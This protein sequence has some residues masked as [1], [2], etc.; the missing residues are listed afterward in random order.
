[1]KIIKKHLIKHHHKED[2]VDRELS[3]LKKI[4][5]PHIVEFIDCFETKSKYYIVFELATG[6]ELFDR[7]CQKGKFTEKDAAIVITT[8]LGAVSFLHS[9]GIVHRDIKPENLLYRDK[10]PNSDL[11]L[12]DFGISKMVESPEELLTTVCGSPGYTAPEILKHEPYSKP[13]DMWSIGVITYTLLC[14]H[15]PF[16]YAEDFNQMYNAICHGRYTFDNIYWAY[17]SRYA[18]DF[19][20]SLLQV[21]P[22]KRLT[23][24]EA[25][26]HTWLVKLCPYQIERI[27]NINGLPVTS[28]SKLKRPI[29]SYSTSA[30]QSE[31]SNGSTK[32]KYVKSKYLITDDGHIPY[33]IL[34]QNS[35]VSYQSSN[36]TTDSDIERDALPTLV[37]YNPVIL[38]M[39]LL[40]ELVIIQ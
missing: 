36:L 26:Q 40:M 8:I 17:I 9:R 10:S 19:I 29:K 27:K 32:T 20:K 3:I 33:D 13:V 24:E 23:A 7:I 16:H 39:Y 15:S 25:L 5:H 31:K 12:C 21:Q 30:A 28:N 18:K 2:M 1:L 35:Y 14:G 4:R 34:H 22:E 38:L 11:L 37:Q 6:G